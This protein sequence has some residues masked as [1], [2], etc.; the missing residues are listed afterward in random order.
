MDSLHQTLRSKKPYPNKVQDFFND[1]SLKSIEELIQN[2]KSINDKHKALNLIEPLNF[3]QLL[4][5]KRSETGP[6]QYQQDLHG[7][8]FPK[9]SRY[10]SCPPILPRGRTLS[11]PS[12]GIQTPK[13]TNSTTSTPET[14]ILNLPPTD[15]IKSSLHSRRQATCRWYDQQK[16]WGFLADPE[17]GNDGTFSRSTVLTCKH[18][19]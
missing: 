6:R 7:T 5:S 2:F 17:L 16:R 3:F 14:K 8:V 15:Q 19:S 1:V 18:M 13:L 4:N 10:L 11:L 12:L 9:R